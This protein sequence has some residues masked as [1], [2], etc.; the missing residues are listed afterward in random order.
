MSSKVSEAVWQDDPDPPKARLLKVG[1][2]AMTDAELLS[3]IIGG[4]VSRQVAAELLNRFDGVSDIARAHVADLGVS[5]SIAVKIVGALELGRR[6]LGPRAERPKLRY[7]PEVDRHYR[8]LL[9]HLHNEVFHVACLDIRNRLLRDARVAEGGFASCAI[10]PREVFA[11]ALRE[12]AVGVILVHNHPSGETE[13]S[14][15]DLQL[16]SR[17]V[18][19][20][21]VLGVRVLDHVIVG[22]GGYTS[23][24]ERGVLR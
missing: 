23:L 22:S 13:P 8:P 2:A 20:G 12:G 9:G 15:D 14:A 24:A 17:L 7:A 16:T 11:P 19:A 1:A 6:S 18:R 5:K 4:A 21:E 3:L 10:L